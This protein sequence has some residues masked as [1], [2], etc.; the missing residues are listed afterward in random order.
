MDTYTITFTDGTTNTFTVTSG[1]DG[2]NGADGANGTTPT[3]EI[4][5]N[6]YWVING[7][8]T[9]VLAR[10]TNGSDGQNGQNGSNGANGKDGADGVGVQSIE[11]TKSEGLIF[12]PP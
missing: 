8:T 2:H 3:I 12:M 10:G 7:V 9:D 4:N 6:G 11:K 5:A 1:A